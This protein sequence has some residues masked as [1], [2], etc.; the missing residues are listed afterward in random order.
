MATPVKENLKIYAGSR[1]EHTLNVQADGVAWPLAGYDARMHFRAEADSAAT[2]F[3]A[4]E[5]NYL[6]VGT[7]SVKI[8]IPGDVSTLWTFEEAVYDLE[9]EDVGGN[10]YR[11]IQGKV[12]VLPEVTR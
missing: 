5:A 10:D 12:K 9:I 4:T 8:D 3:E 11:L 2:L 6:T 7:S 1:Y